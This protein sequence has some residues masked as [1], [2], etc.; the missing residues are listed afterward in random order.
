MGR[1]CGQREKEGAARTARERALC[2]AALSPRCLR[3]HL[4]ETLRRQLVSKVWQSEGGC[5]D[6]GWEQRV[7]LVLTVTGLAPSVRAAVAPVRAWPRGPCAGVAWGPSASVALVS[8]CEGDLG[9]QCKR[10]PGVP[11]RGWP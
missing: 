11:V 8:L 5:L 4:V 1:V 6:G 2:S 10:G 7:V 3:H 9:L